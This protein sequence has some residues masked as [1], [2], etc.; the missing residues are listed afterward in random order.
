MKITA[1]YFSESEFNRAS[2]SCSLQNMKQHT[3]DMMDAVR[4]IAGIPLVVNSAYRSVAH[5]KKMGRTGTSSHTTGRA[6]DIRCNTD[7]N[8]W[9]IID[10]AIKVGFKR[11]GVAKTFIHLDNDTEKSPRV[12]WMY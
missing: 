2:P 8:R 6:I 4:E 1:K 3:M 10:A 7:A 5:E 9:K 11:I 12:I